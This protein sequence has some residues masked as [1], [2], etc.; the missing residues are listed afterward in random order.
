MELIQSANV[1]PLPVPQAYAGRT[2]LCVP[3]FLDIIDQLELFFKVKMAEFQPSPS[4]P[5]PTI[6]FSYLSTYPSHSSRATLSTPAVFT[7]QLRAVLL[8]RL[9]QLVRPFLSFV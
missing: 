2:Q 7:I 6:N 9:F 4:V 5:G 3:G 1:K 8:F